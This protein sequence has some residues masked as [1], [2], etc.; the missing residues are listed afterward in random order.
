MADQ[1]FRQQKYDSANPVM[2]FVLGRFFAR[3]GAAIADL[4]PQS[5]LD[6]GCGEG[7][8]LRR[9]PLP[10][11][12]RAVL[13]D[14]NPAS[15]AHLLAS[16]DALPFADRSFDVVT[17]LEVLEHLD[18]PRPAV[19]ELCRVARRAVVVSV[20]HEPYFRL[21]NLARGKYLAH[22]GN[23]PEHVQHWNF[24]SFQKFLAPSFREV[25]LTGAFPWIIAC[26]R[27]DRP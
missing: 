1:R 11:G 6:A 7:E 16:V 5:L 25:K 13:L 2:R 3:I 10:A 20:P 26:C 23:H 21:G 8:M 12:A 4:A 9:V 18:D 19:R 17:C 15:G 27:P 24:R 14:R 22:L